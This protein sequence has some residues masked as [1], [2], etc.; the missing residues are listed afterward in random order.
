MNL[1]S[2]N[3][4]PP[5]LQDLVMDVV[6]ELEPEQRDRDAA[7]DEEYFQKFLDA[8]VQPI[9]FSPAD[10][11]WFLDTAYNSMWNR[12]L[13]VHSVEGSRLKEMAGQ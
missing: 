9:E 13:E 2:W 1:D 5:H 4:L 11:K 8:G 10:A 6:I 3:Q 12:I 7:K